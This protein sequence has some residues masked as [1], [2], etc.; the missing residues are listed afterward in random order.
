MITATFVVL[1]VLILLLSFGVWRQRQQDRRIDEISRSIAA[2]AAETRA[3]RL[4]T[5]AGQRPRRPD[6]LRSVSR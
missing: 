3:I 2:L 4:L 6:H 1:V 5:Q